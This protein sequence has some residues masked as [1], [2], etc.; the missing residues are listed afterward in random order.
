[1]QMSDPPHKQC[2][3]WEELARH[4][5]RP[6]PA[7]SSSTRPPAGNMGIDPSSLKFTFDDMMRYRSVGTFYVSVYV[8]MSRVSQSIACPRMPFVSHN[9]TTQKA[10]RAQGGGGGA[11]GDGGTGAQ[12]REPAGGMEL[13]YMGRKKA[14]ASCLCLCIL[15][16][17]AHT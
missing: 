2:R 11:G 7:S 13:C 14:C 5:C 12:D 8:C 1:M 4:C 16:V 6:P 3:H 9:T 15:C 10:A 17:R